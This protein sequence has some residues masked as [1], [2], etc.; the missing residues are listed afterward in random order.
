MSGNKLK[1]ELVLNQWR[2]KF[3]PKELKKDKQNK[4]IERMLK[5]SNV[6]EVR[7]TI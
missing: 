4:S 1:S 5:T 3:L 7:F 6:N 2:A